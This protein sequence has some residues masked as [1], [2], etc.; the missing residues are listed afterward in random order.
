MNARHGL[1][2]LGAVG[3]IGVVGAVSLSAGLNNRNSSSSVEQPKL[4]EAAAATIPV[5]GMVCLSCAATI[6]QKLNSLDGVISAEVLLAEQT[7]KIRYAAGDP[8]I[9]AEAAA[10]INSLGYKAGTPV[11]T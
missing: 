1:A 5:K 6:K 10:A 7:V 8:G 2:V 11:R 3:V 9:P 4:T